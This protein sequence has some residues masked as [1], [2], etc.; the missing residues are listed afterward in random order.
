MPSRYRHHPACV[1]R[2]RAADRGRPPARH[3]KSKSW[4]Q[5]FA[6]F[7]RI[8]REA[9]T[10]ETDTAEEDEGGD[11]TPGPRRTAQPAKRPQALSKPP[12][13]S[14]PAAKKQKTYA[15]GAGPASKT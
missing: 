6:F 5:V 10:G 1:R 12:N 13:V 8:E 15:D 7:N 4:G 2:R 3:R 9:Y 14:P 11:A